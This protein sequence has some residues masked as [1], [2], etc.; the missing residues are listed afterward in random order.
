MW[1]STADLSHASS[2]AISESLSLISGRVRL[3]CSKVLERLFKEQNNEVFEFLVECWVEQAA[4]HV[5]LESL[6]IFRSLIPGS[7]SQTNVQI[8]ELLTSSTG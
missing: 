6:V 8:S 2:L 1:S 3:R 7:H 4:G 5:C